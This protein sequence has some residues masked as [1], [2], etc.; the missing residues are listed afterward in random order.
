MHF[1]PRPPCGGR[2]CSIPRDAH[3]THFYPRPPCGGRRCTKPVYHY[4]VHISIHVPRVGDDVD[5]VCFGV[6]ASAFLSTSPVWG[7]T[8]GPGSFMS[9]DAKISIHVPRVGDDTDADGQ[10]WI[11]DDFYP[12][13]PCGGRPFKVQ[14]T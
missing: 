11:C 3:N 12:R 8:A 1:Y 14:G 7:T 13:P 2:H 4:N 6:T 10:Q 5:A 9:P